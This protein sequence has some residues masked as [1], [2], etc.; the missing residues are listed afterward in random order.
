[1]KKVIRLTESNLIRLVK[2]VIKES[3]WIETPGTP[4]HIDYLRDE[5]RRSVER[6]IEND[7]R[8]SHIPSYN[9]KTGRGWKPNQI[10]EFVF[11]KFGLELPDDVIE[12]DRYGFVNDYTVRQWVKSNIRLTER[13][14]TKL[15]RRVIKER[16]TVNS[17]SNEDFTYDIEAVDCDPSQSYKDGT[18]DIEEDNDGNGII[19]IRYCRGDKENLNYLKK[20]GRMI[21]R[22]T[23][24]IS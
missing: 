8:K 17:D 16:E 15:V 14:L 5:E 21:I 9:T 3:S 11:D 20:K 24:G 4:G 13:D 7:E 19:K 18:V 22:S 23:Y 2:K 12:V 6:D 1:M 10:K